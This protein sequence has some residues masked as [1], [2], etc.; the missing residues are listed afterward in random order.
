[1]AKKS[2]VSKNRVA[3]FR[4]Y[5]SCGG[6]VAE[7][8]KELKRNGPEISERTL[9]AWEKRY[10]FER[11][12]TRVDLLMVAHEK[13]TLKGTLVLVLFEQALKY[14]S[15]LESVEVDVGATY[16]LLNIIKTINKELPDESKIDQELTDEKVREV[17]RDVYGFGG[18]K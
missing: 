13:G 12:L 11:R 5:C 10:N 1:M 16:A 17:L 4:A 6:N 9:R 15:Y 14:V 2:L 18:E 7:V 3:V 8:V